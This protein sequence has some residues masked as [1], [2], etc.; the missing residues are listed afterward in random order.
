MKRAYRILPFLLALVSL[1]MPLL[2][3][4][5]LAAPA[6]AEIAVDAADFKFEPKVVTVNVGDTVVWTNTGKVPH[7]V[8]AS[9]GSWDSGRLE[10]GKS[11][12]HTFDSPGTVAYYCK[13]HGSP[14]GNGMAG[15]VQVMAT[16][17]EAP[18]AAP[19]PQQQAPAAAPPQPSSA[20]STLEVSDQPIV[21]NSVTAARVFAAGDGWLVVHTNT[22]DNKPGPVI[23]QSMVM[24][25][26]NGDVKVALSQTPQAGDKL[27]PMLHIDAGQMH[28]YEFPGPDVPVIQGDQI[29]M[30]QIA[31]LPGS[32]GGSS[33]QASAPGQ[34][35]VAPQVAGST[36]QALPAAGEG[37]SPILWV[38]LAAVALSLLLSGAMVLRKGAAGRRD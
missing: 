7:T 23:G 20:E 15:T 27:W 11:F 1:A 33:A 12:S 14:D 31:V 3:G 22:A 13:P 4:S 32:A 6:A 34:A 26:E 5:A 28:Q 17:S 10:P 21:D 19:A 25:G 18:Q 2:A 24:A 37:D 29:V 8:T 16:G 9:D 30:K 36:P 38:T 35:A